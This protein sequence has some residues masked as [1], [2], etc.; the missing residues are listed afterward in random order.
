[1]KTKDNA[2]IFVMSSPNKNGVV[3]CSL[4]KKN[5]TYFSCERKISDLVPENTAEQSLISFLYKLT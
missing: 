4:K 5:G 1:M 3:E 2:T